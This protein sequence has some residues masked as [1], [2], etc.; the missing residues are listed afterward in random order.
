MKCTIAARVWTGG[1]GLLFKTD[2]Y[3]I[4][5]RNQNWNMLVLMGGADKGKF[6]SD[7]GW[8]ELDENENEIGKWSGY[9]FIC[10]RRGGGGL[11]ESLFF[12]KCG[13]RLFVFKMK[14]MEAEMEI[15]SS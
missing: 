6:E 5:E 15:C 2:V 7:G 10:G 13:F 3:I 11:W 8:C 12:L 9:V 14:C 1:I 4:N